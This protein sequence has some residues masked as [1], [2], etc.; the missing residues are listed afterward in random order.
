MSPAARELL[1]GG[2]VELLDQAA[3][4]LEDLDFTDADEAWITQRE[5]D[6]LRRALAD[7]ADFI[8]EQRALEIEGRLARGAP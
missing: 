5:R 3:E 8:H 1:L 7:A 4:T 2:L 6:F